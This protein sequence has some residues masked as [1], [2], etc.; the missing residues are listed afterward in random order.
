MSEPTCDRCDM[1]M[2]KED[3][4]ECEDC[5]ETVCFRCFPVTATFCIDCEASQEERATFPEEFEQ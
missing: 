1:P 2:G 4:R 3:E 5:S